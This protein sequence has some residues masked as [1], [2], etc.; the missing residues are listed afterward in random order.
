VSLEK[1][2]SRIAMLAAQGAA[3]EDWAELGL[4]LTQVEQQI[5]RLEFKFSRASK[6]KLISNSLLRQ[7]SDDLNAA[8]RKAEEANQKLRQSEAEAR[9]L[10]LIAARTDNAVILTDAQGLT[11]WVNEGFVR[12]T[13]YTMDEVRGRKP[14]HLLRGP[15]TD[16]ATVAYMRE[17]IARGEG[18]SV[19]LLNYT[20]EG[21]KYW[22]F[23]EVQP[24]YDAQGRVVNFMAIQ[25]DITERKTAEAEL[26]RSNTLQRAILNGANYAI[27]SADPEGI[28][29][30]FNSAAEKMLGYSAEEM[31]GKLTPAVI[32]DPAEIAARAAEL[33]LELGQEISPGFD[34]FTAKARQG[35]PD[36][37]EWT[38]VRKD[39]IRFPVMLSVTGL[40]DENGQVTGYVGIASDITESKRSAAEL[41][42]ARDAAEAA[43]KAKSDFLAVM[44]HEIRTP[45]NAVIGMSGLLLDTKLEPRQREYV[46]AVHNSGE[47]L[48]EIINDILD[49]S[50]I[51]SAQLK[52]EP[53]DFEFRV[54]TDGVIELLAPRAQGKGLEF[55]AIVAADVPFVLMGD[56]GRL[57][58]VLVNLL[59]NAI[60][61]TE[62][63]RV[64]MRVACARREPNR[65][66]LRFD[67]ID[68]GIGIAPD[69]QVKLFNPF[70]QADST[71]RR[72]YGGTGLGLAICKRLVEL[73]GG[74]IGLISAPGSGSTF[75]F[76][77][78][79]GC[80]PQA[81]SRSEFDFSS[82]FVVVADDQASSAESA[83][84][85]LAAWGVAGTRCARGE[86][87]LAAVRRARQQGVRN[88]VLLAD[89][90][91]PDMKGTDLA[92]L[93]TEDPLTAGTRIVLLTH[94]SLMNEPVSPLRSD[95]WLFKPVKQS[96]LF[97]Y[98]VSLVHTQ[99]TVA[100]KP[101]AASPAAP[102]AGQNL[103]I[104]VA[105]DHEINRRLTMLVLEKLGCK[106]EY[107][108]D[109]L[110]VLETW[111]RGGF[112][113]ILM[114]CQ[115]P[116]VDGFEA[117]REIRLLE[118]KQTGAEFRRTYIIA[119]TA[120]ALADERDNC[121]ASGMDDYLSKPF[122]TE[123]LREALQ[124]GAVARGLA[125][126][127]AT[128]L[129]PGKL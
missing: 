15:E 127:S 112:D 53:H 79:F 98:L 101:M 104:L 56:D 81:A 34:A 32:H 58:Q 66:R 71:T 36:E 74:R 91:L 10:A 27:I 67:I 31:I 72:Q 78:D 106:A 107:A 69:Q 61:F 8:L 114:D 115:M 85:M 92:Q 57:R 111:K 13:G 118:A 73:M 83:E 28:I 90:R 17:R 2:K 110:E 24:I 75:W 44:S 16:P 122:R 119:L 94:R 21:R 60:K 99:E 116:F 87:A 113:V 7:T 86:S 11:E 82:V 120:N 84:A 29:V 48:L 88:V 22:L 63:G 20:K 52:L 105:E 43:N 6:D 14:G 25:S 38:Y 68:T 123:G 126:R 45:M 4:L 109:G 125:V 42:R 80:K 64:V 97:N 3:P 89:E 41:V 19:E 65:V 121:I 26:R 39:G 103:R 33:T 76:E 93:I 128:T 18:Y 35:R 95:A 40:F 1:L 49:F 30:T 46:E 62:D 12:L 100:A 5:L 54:L 47:A 124:R 108:R 117:T 55:A 96:Q 37:R 23:I 50:K 129:V 51:E 9:K 77:A 102:F 70:T 59:T